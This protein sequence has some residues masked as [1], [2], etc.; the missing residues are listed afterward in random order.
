[1]VWII[2]NAEV[3][4]QKISGLLPSVGNLRY[5]HTP[6]IRNRIFA[7]PDVWLAPPHWQLGSVLI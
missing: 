5:L 1:M 6:E 7:A 3:F 2:K 4:S